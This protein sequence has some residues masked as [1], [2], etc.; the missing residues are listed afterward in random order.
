[1]DVVQVSGSVNE[2]Y[3]S[4]IGLCSYIPGSIDTGRYLDAVPGGKV[5]DL[6][7]DPRETEPF[8]RRREG[9][10]LQLR[11]GFEISKEKLSAKT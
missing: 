10:L 9:E 5:D 4:P 8:F 3:R 7:F 11:I 6:R 2:D 1:M